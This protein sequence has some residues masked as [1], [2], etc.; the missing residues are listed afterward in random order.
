MSLQDPRQLCSVLELCP[1]AGPGPLHTVLSQKMAQLLGTLLSDMVWPLSPLP[2][3]MDGVVY[4]FTLFS[5]SQETPPLC[6]I[7]ELT[8][9]AV[10]S[11]LENN[12]TEEQLV[13]DMEKV[14]YLLPHSILGQCKDFVDSYG[15][16]VVVM[17]LDATDPQAVCTMLH[18]CPRRGASRGAELRAA[19]EP[20]A[21][22]FCNVCQILITYLDNEL[23]KNETMTE[24]GD[25]LE[26][27]CE[28]LPAPLITTCEALVVQY[29]P[30]A[31]RLF[32]QMMDPDFV[33]TK[34]RA[35]DSQ[36]L[37]DPCVQGPNY[38]CTSMATATECDAVEHCRQHVWN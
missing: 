15:K 4:N 32:V 22:A 13:N 26:K 6:E 35:C 36:L 29:E 25:V 30:A 11:L 12:M 28:L 19:L 3:R 8:V 10:E 7:C 27:G 9:R 33:C 23:L 21:G 2:A 5:P 31:M 16:A 14:C 37:S 17:L 38:W 24:L 18:I 34:L 1:V 20:A